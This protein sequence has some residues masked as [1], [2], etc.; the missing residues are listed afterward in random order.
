M[1]H[2]FYLFFLCV[3]VLKDGDSGYCA[4]LS[5]KPEF[6]SNR[7]FISLLIYSFFDGFFNFACYFMFVNKLICVLQ[8][9]LR[10]QSRLQ[11]RVHISQDSAGANTNTEKSPTSI[12]LDGLCVYVCLCMAL[13]AVKKKNFFFFCFYDIFFL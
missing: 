6:W 1:K 9:N 4:L 3:C 13:T 7:M 2:L 10:R 8:L 5:I 12:D 11:T